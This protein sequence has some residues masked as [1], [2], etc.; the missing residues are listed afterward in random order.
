[1]TGYCTTTWG[2]PIRA[3]TASGNDGYIAKLDGNG[4]LLWNTFLGGS[5]GD[6]CYHVAIDTAGN[7]CVTGWSNSTWESPVRPYSGGCDVLVAKV[8]GGGVLQWNTFLGSATVVDEGWGI[9]TDTSGNVYVAGKGSDGFVAKLNTGGALQW[10]TPMGGAGSDIAHGVTV[11]GNGDV[12]VV[13]YS[14]TTWGSPVTPFVT[15]AFDPFV[16]MFTGTSGVL[17]WNLFLGGSDYNSHSNI[18]VDTDGSIFI[19]GESSAW[20]S[21]IRAYTSSTDAFLAKIQA[22][23]SPSFILSASPTSATVSAGQTAGYAIQVIPQSGSFD[24]VVSF[25]CSGLPRGCTATFSPTSVTPGANIVASSLTL[26]TKSNS[27]LVVGT[28]IGRIG[29]LPLVLGILLTSLTILFGR[30]ILRSKPGIQRR[31]WLKAG[32]MI[33]LLVIIAS[34]S[35][36]DN[37]N[38]SNDGTPAGTYQISVQGQAGIVTSSTTVTLVVN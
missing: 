20:G 33:S 6:G 8:N 36:G 22:A 10:T 1:M 4:T 35:A 29:F 31:R 3:F 2:S 23:S 14:S 32:A 30:P 15:A 13:G 16:A 28:L 26:C 7:A 37:G 19:V 12:Y 25:S 9:H 38:S 17:Q 24:S 18:T 5:Q 34:C 11:A 27:G 21:P